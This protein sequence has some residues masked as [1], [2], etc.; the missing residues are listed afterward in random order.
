MGQRSGKCCLTRGGLT[1][2]GVLIIRHSSMSCSGIKRRLAAAVAAIFTACVVGA[3][4][5][6]QEERVHVLAGTGWPV[7]VEQLA[8]VL[9]AA[10]GAA[11]PLLLVDEGVHVVPECRR[12]HSGVPEPRDCRL[13]ALEQRRIAEV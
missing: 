3:E 12:A 13:V 8:Q 4:E 10:E 7:G 11:V 1:N 6:L 2:D 5:L 9:H